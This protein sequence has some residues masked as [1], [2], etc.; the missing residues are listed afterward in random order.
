M[1]KLFRSEPKNG[2]RRASLCAFLIV[3]LLLTLPLTL[4]LPCAAESE[5]SREAVEWQLSE[6][7]YTLIGNGRTY[8]RCN[9]LPIGQKVNTDTLYVF[10]N[11]VRLDGR[12]M[13]VVASSPDAE[14]VWLTSTMSDL[15]DDPYATAVF[16]TKEGQTALEAMAAGQMSAWRLED[17]NSL[18]GSTKQAFFDSDLLR[19]M[20]DLTATEEVDVSSLKS[21]TRYD[22]LGYDRTGTVYT[23]CGAVYKDADRYLYVNYLT[24]GNQY[25]DAD[26]NFSY[27][28]G[29]V[30]AVRL[31]G[32]VL[33][34][35]LATT[36]RLKAVSASVIYEDELTFDPDEEMATSIAAFWGCLIIFGF[37][38][39]I[40][41]LVVGLVMPHS[42]K[43]GCPTRW[44]LVA[45]LSA[46]W[47]AIAI[48]IAILAA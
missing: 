41:P 12:T 25:F 16:A 3:A 10:E 45:L 4:S 2:T 36:E 48:V 34:D 26:G 43:R 30:S 21:C 32:D 23:V 17:D 24:L 1:K 20:N 18:F 44:Y 33:S 40:A 19:R 46:V 42:A 9:E 39:P 29:Q 22:I 47:I 38:L 6:D 31:E 27:R 5:T 7:E 13:S 28:S 35:F 37:I 15:W 14:I 11:T 8:T